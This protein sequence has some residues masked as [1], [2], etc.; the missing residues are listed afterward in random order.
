MEFAALYR[1]QDKACYRLEA[2]DGLFSPSGGLLLPEEEQEDWDL[3]SEITACYQ[4]KARKVASADPDELPGEE[5]SFGSNGSL[6]SLSPA[7]NRCSSE[8]S[9]C[10]SSQLPAQDHEPVARQSSC[11]A[12]LVHSH[13][14]YIRRL[15]QLQLESQRL[16][17]EGLSP[18]LRRTAQDAWQS[19]PSGSGPTRLSPHKVSL[20]SRSSF[21][22]L[23]STTTSPSA[24][25]LSSLDSAFSYCSESSAPSPLGVCSLPLMF[26]TAARLQALSPKGAQRALAEWHKPWISPLPLPP[27]DLEVCVEPRKNE[28]V[29]ITSALGSPTHEN[30]WGEGKGEAGP[31]EIL[32]RVLESHCASADSGAPVHDVKTSSLASQREIATKH[33]QIKSAEA[34]PCGRESLKRTK[35]TVYMAPKERSPRESP[36]GQ[37]DDDAATSSCSSDDGR[38]RGAPKSLQTVRVHI[39][40][41][42]FYGQNT[43]LVLQSVARKYHHQQSASRPLQTASAVP[44]PGHPD[45]RTV[46]PPSPRQDSSGP[47][48]HT[49]QIFLP[50]SIRTTVRQYFSHDGQRDYGTAGEAAVEKE[51]LRS[52]AEW[53]RT[54]PCSRTPAEELMLAEETFV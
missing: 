9:V 3:F 21:S 44:P 39:P 11:D 42:V 19:V 46:R 41:T 18:R 40:Q 51:L 23:S 12:T 30:A 15:K 6:C 34:G 32:S 31:G 20:S 47:F 26:G 24:S 5:G 10:L 29:P 49:L 25:S 37:D 2:G 45:P 35:I 43:P 16:I 27:G 28:F 52:R 1:D 8:P 4:S 54:Q 38:S 50:A 36:V 53:L 7:R 22:S 17:E 14:D 33:I 48:G 13:D